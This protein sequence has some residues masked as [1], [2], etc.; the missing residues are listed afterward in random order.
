MHYMGL[1]TD[2]IVY[3]MNDILLLAFVHVLYSS[4]VAYY[5]LLLRFYMGLITYYLTLHELYSACYWLFSTFLSLSS[6]AS[7]KS[8]IDLRVSGS[9]GI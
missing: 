3:F 4:L 7:I 2:P 8:L 6:C 1:I 5:W 9:E